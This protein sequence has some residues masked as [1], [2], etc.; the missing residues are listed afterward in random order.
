VC[1]ALDL[2]RAV[3]PELLEKVASAAETVAFLLREAAT[4]REARGP[5]APAPGEEA[6]DG[7]GAEDGEDGGDHEGGQTAWA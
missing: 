1:R 6:E 2:A 4:A 5:E 3:Q 7:E